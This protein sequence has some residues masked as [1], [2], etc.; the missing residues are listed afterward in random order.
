M[1]PAVQGSRLVLVALRPAEVQFIDTL[2]GEMRSVG[3]QGE[4]PGEFR[5]PTSAWFDGQA[6]RIF[7]PVLGRVSAFGWGGDFLGLVEG[8]PLANSASPLG[9]DK[10]YF[11]SARGA[12]FGFIRASDGVLTPVG[13][14]SGPTVRR[15]P[16]R[17]VAD[18]HGRIFAYETAV[19][20][21][22]TFDEAGR[23]L[24][25]PLAIPSWLAEALAEQFSVMVAS[26]RDK[27][28][29]IDE[30]APL[31]KFLVPDQHGGVFLFYAVAGRHE[32]GFAIH[33]DPDRQE[34]TR[35]QYPPEPMAADMLF[36][37]ATGASDGK[38]LLISGLQGTRLFRLD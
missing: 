20:L 21:L 37:A 13:K 29:P 26:S 12:Q 24:H 9:T 17:S 32:L 16:N 2:S 1:A 28:P 3:R 22:H 19:G 18:G 30:R 14:P 38:L 33:F 36:R 8:T 7:D 4:G 31:A 23:P 6:V 5:A 11:E 25:P 15:A 10:L 27:G 35:L 34:F